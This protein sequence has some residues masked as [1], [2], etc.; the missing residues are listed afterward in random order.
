MILFMAELNYG[1]SFNGTLFITNFKNV[2]MYNTDA[3]ILNE[4]RNDRHKELTDR[5][6]KIRR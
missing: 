6:L 2:C 3:R 1:V 5:I 4:G